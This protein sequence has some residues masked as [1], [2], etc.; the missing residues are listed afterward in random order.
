MKNVSINISSVN[1]KE[2][3]TPL[4]CLESFR[5][6]KKIGRDVPMTY[7]G[8][9][10]P[11]A[12][13]LMIILAGEECKNKDKYLQLDKEYEFEVLFGFATDTY[14]ILGK[15]DPLP[16]SPLPRGRWLKAGGGELEKLIKKNLKFFKG[17]I[18]QKY[19]MYSSK[20]VA[21]KQLHEYARNGEEVEAPEHEVNVKSLKFLKIRK[22]NAQTLLKN[23][24]KRISKV[25]IKN[26]F[27]QKEIL[28]IWQTCVRQDLTQSYL[29]GSFSARVS[30]GTY[31]R[32]ISNDL[33]EKIG[34]PAL[35]Y[36][37]KRTKV[38]KFVNI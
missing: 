32:T 30:S 37:I 4:E 13:G 28:K 38:G 24:E 36:S 17:K 5:I 15:I 2:G 9:L 6:K 21:G 33:G 25:N 35:A 12:S 10:D 20:T 31:I 11:M 19:P 7:A 8:R 27:R 22:I 34:I 16:A 18:M 23:I 3:E 1:K 29:I 26:D 14:D